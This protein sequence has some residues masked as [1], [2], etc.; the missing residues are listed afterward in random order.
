MFTK[1][2]ALR[3]LSSRVDAIY[4]FA[5]EG[6]SI[7]SN[8]DVFKQLVDCLADMMLDPKTPMDRVEKEVKRVEKDF[9]LCPITHAGVSLF[10][11]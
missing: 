1:Q 2:R 11:T 7:T 8:T 9:Y 4:D 10:W 3:E 6:N 5:Q